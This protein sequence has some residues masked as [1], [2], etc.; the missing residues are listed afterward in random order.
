[1]TVGRRA[2]ALL[3][4][5][6]VASGCAA[7]KREPTATAGAAKP[8]ASPV[9][10]VAPA[11]PAPSV[12]PSAPAPAVR[13]AAPATAG[14]APPP[15]A[16]APK[17]AAAA[18]NPRPAPRAPVPPVTAVAPS[19]PAVKPAPVPPALPAVPAPA[20]AVATLDLKSLEQRLRE[21][22]A[23]G[24]FTKLALKNQVDDLLDKFRAHHAGKPNPPVAELRQNFDGLMMKVLTL[25]QDG[26][27][28][29]AKTIGSSRDA[30]W[31]ILNDPV[32]LTNI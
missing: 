32:K 16:V 12:A 10:A 4:T 6:L 5:L 14:V 26:D 8:A 18:P 20:P 17:P 31:N 19:P 1:M 13:A 25:L 11:A 24:V 21:T 23:I 29:L 27:P 7:T 28:G 30:L 2:A 22:R 15:V 9:A 3:A